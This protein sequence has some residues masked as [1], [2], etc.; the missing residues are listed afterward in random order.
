MILLMTKKGQSPIPLVFNSVTHMKEMSNKDGPCREIFRHMDY[1]KLDR[2]DA[3][4]LIS[5]ILLAVDCD[6]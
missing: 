3:M 2:I 5:C 1:R 6:F 4:E